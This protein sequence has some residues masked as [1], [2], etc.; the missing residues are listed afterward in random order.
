MT[1]ARITIFVWNVTY[2][3][4]QKWDTISNNSIIVI[5]TPTTWNQ[6]ARSIKNNNENMRLLFFSMVVLLC[7]THNCGFQEGSKETPFISIIPRGIL[8]DAHRLSVSRIN[9]NLRPK[10]CHFWFHDIISLPPQLK[11]VQ[12]HQISHGSLARS[13]II[14]RFRRFQP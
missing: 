12:L 1:P 4:R 7:T 9:L 11:S 10:S 13:L 14:I 6:L 3:T 2:T 5:E 8:S